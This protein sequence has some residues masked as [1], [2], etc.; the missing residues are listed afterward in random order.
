MS[1]FG[2]LQIGNGKQLAEIVGR[3][4]IQGRA[5]ESFYFGDHAL[6]TRLGDMP[7]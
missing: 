3:I 7:P 1:V 5:R 6:F 4:N 2:A